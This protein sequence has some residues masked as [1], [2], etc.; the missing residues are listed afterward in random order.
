LAF[1]AALLASDWAL[2]EVSDKVTSVSEIW[3]VGI[4]AAMVCF[5]GAYLRPWSLVLLVPYPV[6]WF[7]SLLIESHLSDIADALY[8][9]QGAT[10]YAQAYASLALWLVGL[11]VGWMAGRKARLHR[12][13]R[14]E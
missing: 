2:A 1:A 9:E 11:A 5:L 6:Y 14:V 3:S 8:Q 4:I 7:A 10:Y 13:E 12:R